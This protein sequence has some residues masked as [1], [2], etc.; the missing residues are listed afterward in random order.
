MGFSESPGIE[1]GTTGVEGDGTTNGELTDC[2]GVPVLVTDDRRFCWS[3]WG[4]EFCGI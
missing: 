3:S 4:E 2:K 1:D